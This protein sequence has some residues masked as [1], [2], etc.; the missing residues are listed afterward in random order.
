MFFLVLFLLKKE[1]FLRKH[2]NLRTV[3]YFESFVNELK[4]ELASN[5]FP[6]FFSN[7]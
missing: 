6:V 3:I 4:I 1:I 2:K 5:I 7:G